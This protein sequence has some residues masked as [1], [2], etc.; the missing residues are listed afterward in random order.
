MENRYLGVWA[1]V[2][3]AEEMVFSVIRRLERNDSALF[4]KKKTDRKI[5]EER[6]WISRWIGKN[7]GEWNIGGIAGTRAGSEYIKFSFGG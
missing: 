3:D 6:E 4:E 1:P 2:N 5:G 7:D